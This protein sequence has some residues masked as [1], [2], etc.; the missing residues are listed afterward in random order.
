[1]EDWVESGIGF[2]SGPE[3]ESLSQFFLNLKGQGDPKMRLYMEGKF[4]VHLRL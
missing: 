4:L 3:R 2:S 1:M